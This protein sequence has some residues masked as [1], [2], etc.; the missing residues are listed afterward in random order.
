MDIHEE[1]LIAIRQIIRAT[2][3]HS[4]KINKDFGLTSPQLLLMR[5][6][7]S[8]ENMTIRQLSSNTNMSQATATS[9]LDRLEKRGLITRQRDQQDKRKVHALLTASGNQLLLNAPT[10]LQDN[11]IDQ[12]QAL[13]SWEQTLILSSLQRISTM[14]QT[15]EIE[16]SALTP[17]L[18]ANDPF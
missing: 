15:S 18:E 2:D 12:F 6:I 11:F 9:I 1:V 8:S 14:M 5:E 10:L 4:K 17:I 13:S 7:Q 3:L 16:P